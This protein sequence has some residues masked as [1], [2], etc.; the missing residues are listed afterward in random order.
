MGH[1][2][3]HAGVD[4]RARARSA[5]SRVARG[6]GGEHSTGGFNQQ[7]IGTAIAVRHQR[8][9]HHEIDGPQQ[10]ANGVQHLNAH[11]LLTKQILGQ[12]R[13]AVARRSIER[14]AWSEMA[15]FVH[16]ALHCGGHHQR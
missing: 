3:R 6:T 15:M 5:E 12:R 1:D 13:R 14:R 7:T 8:D 16:D 2:E 10:D 11:A 9:V 4:L